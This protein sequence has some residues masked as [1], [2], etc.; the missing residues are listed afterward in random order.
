VGQVLTGSYKYVDA[1]DNLEGT[2]TFRWLRDNVVIP[3]ATDRRYALVAVDEGTLIRFEVTP[4]A[5]SGFSPGLAVT[6]NPV[7]PVTP[8]PNPPTPPTASSVFISGTPRVGQVLTGSYTYADT[9]GDSEGASTFRWLRGTT[10]IA[11]ATAKSYA[12]VAADEG[13]LIR[14]EVTPVAQSGASPG[15]AVTSAAVGPVIPEP[16]PP[17]APTASG[18][19][20]SGTPRVGQVLTGSYTYGDVEEDLEGA[21]TF[22]WLR[23]N[24]VIAG[25]TA[26]SYALVAADEEALI[27]FEVTPV[28][29]SGPSPGL[30]VTSTAV[31]PVTPDPDP[32]TPPMASS[33]FISGAPQVGQVLTGSYTYA[34][35]EGDLEGASTFR[36]LR[37]RTPIA[38]ATAET[39]T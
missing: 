28:A 31:G 27:R 35:T 26:R 39:Y 18:V 6:S 15:L 21:S 13:A 20:I 5:Q 9:E 30:A 38:G 2:S 17:T 14:F 33:V 34:D 7:G 29:Q 36:W 10:A 4:V 25:A 19:S 12:L 22:R 23:D 37:D 24:V 16:N 1:E 11:G 8:A 3:G 32:P